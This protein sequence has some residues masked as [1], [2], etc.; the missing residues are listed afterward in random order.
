MGETSSQQS[1]KQQPATK[2]KQAKAFFFTTAGWNK[3][4][5]IFWSLDCGIDLYGVLYDVLYVA[6][7]VYGRYARCNMMG[8][9]Q[10]V[11][12]VKGK[13]IDADETPQI[14][15]LECV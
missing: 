8:L 11:E 2:N 6:L 14:S 13:G 15:A 12:M 3:N 7:S 10:K 1:S 4:F 5:I 9:I